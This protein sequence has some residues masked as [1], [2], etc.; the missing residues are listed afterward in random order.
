M[1]SV[2]SKVECG[3]VPWHGYCVRAATAAKMIKKDLS[4]GHIIKMILFGD[5]YDENHYTLYIS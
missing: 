1:I 5:L 3:I 2:C 4:Q